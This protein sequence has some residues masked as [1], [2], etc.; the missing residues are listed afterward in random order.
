MPAPAPPPV[1]M[2]PQP[3]TVAPGKPA[4]VML[5]YAARRSAMTPAAVVASGNVGV[6]TVPVMVGG[7]PAPQAP[8]PAVPAPPGTAAA[9]Q[10]GV[11]V[12]STASP[13]SV[14]PGPVV[15]TPARLAI[16]NG[17]ARPRMAECTPAPAGA[18]PPAPAAPPKIFPSSPPL[19]HPAISP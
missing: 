3:S 19:P 10:V 11:G 15:V 1:P 8:K 6:I 14:A 13:V 18:T 4:G 17:V 5:L 16:A 2:V 12:A 9:L 7:P